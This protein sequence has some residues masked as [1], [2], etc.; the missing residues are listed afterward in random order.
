MKF[1][2]LTANLIGVSNLLKVVSNDRRLAILCHLAE[3]ELS[4]GDIQ[5][6]IGLSQSALSQHLARLRQDGVVKTRRDAQ[7]IYYRIDERMMPY[8]L[9]ILNKMA[10]DYGA[11][12]PDDITDDAGPFKMAAQ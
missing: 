10:R 8:V 1:P 2:Y 5:R 11:F 7:N 9:D 3:G 6:L 4:V 12:L